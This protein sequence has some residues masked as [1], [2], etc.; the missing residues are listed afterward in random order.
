MDPVCHRCGNALHEGELFCAHCGAPQLL[1]EAAEPGAQQQQPVRFRGDI[2]NVQWQVAITSALLVSLPVG[3]LSALAGLSSLFVIGGGFATIA[4]YRRRTM[5]ATDGS[6]GWRIGT[7][8]GAASAT[9]ASAV[10]AARMLVVRYLLHHGATIDAEFSTVA[11]QL[12]DQLLKSNP[13]AV[14]Q[15][16]QLFH[17]WA[18][19]WLSADGHAAIRLLIAAVVSLGMIVFAGAGGAIAGRLLAMRAR[20]QRSL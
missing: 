5:A 20:V 4:L 14:Q 8:L 1:V 17:N 18:N 19:F 13:E 16:P 9:V 3:L 11:Q 2:H 7:I 10:D 12:S 15:A 6:I